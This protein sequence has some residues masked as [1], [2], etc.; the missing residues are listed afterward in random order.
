MAKRTIHYGQRRLIEDATKTEHLILAGVRYGKSYL[1]PAWHFYRVRKN[2][3]S[4]LSL[5]I[6][7]DYKLAKQVCL[8][9]YRDFL[10]A[11][12]LREGAKGDFVI[13]KGD[14]TIYFPKLDHTVVTLSG[15]KPE[16]II[17]Y[18]S[19]HAWIDESASCSEEVRNNVLMRNS[20]PH[21]EYVQTLHTTTPIGQNWLYNIFGP[22]GSDAYAA[23]PRID[24]TPYSENDTKLVLHGRT[25]DNP[26]LS[27]RYLKMLEAEF[28]WNKAYYQN[29]ILGE[30][31]SLAQDRFYFEFDPD[32]NVGEYPPDPNNRQLVLTFDNNVG[33][34]AWAALQ[35]Q[36]W[37]YAVVDCNDSDARN[38]DDAVLQIIKRFPPLQWRNHKI[39]VLGDASLHHRSNQSYTTGYQL[40]KHLLTSAYRDVE[41]KAHI[42]NPLVYERS[43]TTNRRFAE[44]RLRI[45]R[46]CKKVIQS[47]K[48]VESDGKQGVKK[49]SNDFITHP[50]EAVDMALVV[51]DPFKIYDQFVGLK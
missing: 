36:P 8:V 27:S 43:I 6:A 49:K 44:N 42:G 18:T 1:G 3:N 20:C 25:M 19:S 31:V 34:M 14:L 28:A 37:G 16:K 45:N 47:A 10:L 7:P 5:V 40:L 29:Y 46:G 4:K 38:V 22:D 41:I 32:T 39:T 48:S 26:W 50:M 11:S 2:K 21:A 33:K 15:E 23:V 24:G 30:W 17:G 51:L 13:N 35:P 9:Y 12:N